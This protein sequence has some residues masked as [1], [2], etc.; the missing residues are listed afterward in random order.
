MEQE[1]ELVT[2]LVLELV[3][4]LV[5]VLVTELVQAGDRILIMETLIMEMDIEYDFCFIYLVSFLCS[6]LVSFHFYSALCAF[7]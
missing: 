1:L 2:E 4:E 7:R 5:L 6:D 3:T